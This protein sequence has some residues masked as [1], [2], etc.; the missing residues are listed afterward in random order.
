VL[1]QKF[2]TLNTTHQ[3]LAAAYQAAQ[4]TMSQIQTELTVLQT[5]QRLWEQLTQ[6]VMPKT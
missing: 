3:N 2:D 4:K 1:T 6:T 5:E